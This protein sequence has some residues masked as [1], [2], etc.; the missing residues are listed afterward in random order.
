MHQLL[1]G[2]ARVTMPYSISSSAWENFL[3]RLEIYT[4]IPATPLIIDIIIKILVEEAFQ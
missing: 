1:V 2:L 4:T 3:E